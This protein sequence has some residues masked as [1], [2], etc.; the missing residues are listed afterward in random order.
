ML[1]E[2]EKNK[3]WEDKIRENIKEEQKWIDEFA[4]YEKDSDNSEER[5]FYRKYK[6]E[7]VH[8]RNAFLELL[9]E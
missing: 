2:K 1:E 7:H 5:A 9:E 4:E 8:R 3:Q 6:M